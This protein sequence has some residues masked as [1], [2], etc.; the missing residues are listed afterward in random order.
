MQC[1]IFLWCTS[2]C[3]FFRYDGRVGEI[4]VRRKN[5]C[6]VFCEV[7]FLSLAFWSAQACG[8][9]FCYLRNSQPFA[10]SPTKLVRYGES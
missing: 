7:R 2:I 9:S 4:W 8:A 10:V 6:K 3:R 1:F 5:A